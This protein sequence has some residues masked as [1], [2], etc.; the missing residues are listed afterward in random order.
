MT[1]RW[2]PRC[3]PP[4]GLVTP[5]PVDVDGRLGPTKAQARGPYWRRTSPGLYVPI[6]VSCVVV[7]QRILEAA[8]RLPPGGA[9]SGWA[10]LRMAGG[11]F[12][13]GLEPD[14]RTPWPVRL[15][16]PPDR[17]LRVVGH[18]VVGRER[19]EASEIVTLHGVPCTTPLRATFDE[20]R[21]CSSLREAVVAVDMALAAGLITLEEFRAYANRRR[22]WP[23][24]RMAR[25]A[26]AL[27]DPRSLSPGET[28][29]RLVWVL[30][31]RRPPPLCNWPI[32]DLS[33]QR[34][35]KPDLL[36]DELGVAGEYNG[37]DHR[38]ATRHARDVAREGMFRNAGLEY[39]T[40]VG[41]DQFDIPLVLDRINA[42]CH[43]ALTARRPRGWLIARDPGPP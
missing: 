43:R 10:A 39:F 1:H 7:E 37:A 6:G 33:G 20:A 30:D 29:M 17:N 32:A 19:L 40:V 13:D 9:V 3:P 34:L 8:Q 18:V 5:R 23:G 41:P 36:S 38:T 28:R 42:T 25:A 27:A 24:A 16:V 21:G 11:G 12:F 35:G 31:A 4:A 14:G 2:Q 15:V 26:A 22:G